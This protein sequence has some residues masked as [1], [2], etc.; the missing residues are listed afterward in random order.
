MYVLLPDN[1]NLLHKWLGTINNSKIIKHTVQTESN[2]EPELVQHSVHRS[3]VYTNF[4]IMPITKVSNTIFTERVWFNPKAT[5]PKHSEIVKFLVNN[6][7]NKG[8]VGVARTFLRKNDNCIVKQVFLLFVSKLHLLPSRAQ[9]SPSFFFLISLVFSTVLREAILRK[10]NQ[11]YC[12]LIGSPLIWKMLFSP[13]SYKP[14][15]FAVR[16]NVQHKFIKLQFP[17]NFPL[18]TLTYFVNFWFV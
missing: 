10:K 14:T 17:F 11:S 15:S 12:A 7:S 9:Q 1:L 6:Y 8:T 16:Q 5:K 13:M 18:W 2:C 3:K 4:T